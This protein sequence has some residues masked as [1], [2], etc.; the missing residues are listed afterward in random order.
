MMRFKNE[1]KDLLHIATIENFA[2]LVFDKINE[3]KIIKYCT[4]T[5]KNGK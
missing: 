2:F 3:K 4:M 5:D 1:T